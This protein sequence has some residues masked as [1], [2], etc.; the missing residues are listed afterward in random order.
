MEW[1]S[2]TEHPLH[3]RANQGARVAK[4]E[5]WETLRRIG[6]RQLYYKPEAAGLAGRR[7][8]T[9]KRDHRRRLQP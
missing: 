5:R 7:R 2:V 4:L 3:Q 8:W 9:T 1:G 6:A